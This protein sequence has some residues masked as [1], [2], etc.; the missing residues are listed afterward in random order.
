MSLSAAS[1][2]EMELKRVG[3]YEYNLNLFAHNNTDYNMT[4]GCTTPHF[5]SSTA[6]SEELSFEED[7]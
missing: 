6:G 3:T 1:V 7:E 2:C 5:L 4:F